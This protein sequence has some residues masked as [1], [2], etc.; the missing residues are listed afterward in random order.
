MLLITHFFVQS[1]FQRIAE[2]LQAMIDRRMVTEGTDAW[3]YTHTALQIAL[4]GTDQGIMYQ[5]K[6]K[7]TAC[8]R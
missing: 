6:K 5:R 7:R 1:K 2:T 3:D 4:S 8:S